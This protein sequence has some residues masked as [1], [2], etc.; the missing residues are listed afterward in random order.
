MTSFA[1]CKSPAL[2]A[3]HAAD[4]ARAANPPPSSVAPPA[5]IAAASLHPPRAIAQG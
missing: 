3:H 5:N 2:T 4:G 1:H